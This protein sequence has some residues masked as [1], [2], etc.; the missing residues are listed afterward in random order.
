MNP[1][2]AN[3][4]L[5]FL[6]TALN[7]VSFIMLP[8]FVAYWTV[9]VIDPFC[10]TICTEGIV[11]SPLLIFIYSCFSC[12]AALTFCASF[13]FPLDCLFICNFWD[14]DPSFGIKT[15][16]MKSWVAFVAYQSVITSGVVDWSY[17]ILIWSWVYSRKAVLAS[18]TIS[19]SPWIFFAWDSLKDFINTFRMK[20]SLTMI[21]ENTIRLFKAF[22]ALRTRHR[23]VPSEF[24]NLC[25]SGRKHQ[26]RL[27]L[28]LLEKN[29]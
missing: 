28:W 10:L 12:S 6:K 19:T 18:N 5:C 17:L 1:K 3:C 16:K 23:F 7:H 22:T 9:L 13:T 11:S 14:L 24:Y 26:R 8:E 25:S 27:R 4:I 29:F 21:T 2:I 20:E 15:I